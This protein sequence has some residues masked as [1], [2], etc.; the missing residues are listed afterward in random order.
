MN[1]LTLPSPVQYRNQEIPRSQPELLFHEILHLK[2]PLVDLLAFNH[3][4]TEVEKITLNN[5]EKTALPKDKKKIAVQT[6]I[7]CKYCVEIQIHI[8][9]RV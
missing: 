9:K 5:V 7:Q 6:K 1:S 4:N 8:A 2:E 3:F